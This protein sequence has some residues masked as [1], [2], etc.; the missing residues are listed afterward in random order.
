MAVTPEILLDAA[1]A[2]GK[3]TAE[4]DRRNAVSRAYYAAFHRCRSVAQ[5]ARLSVAETGSVHVALIDALVAPLTPTPLKSIGY[6]LDQ[7]RRMR[8]DADYGIDQDFP[9]YLA[10]NVLRNCRKI[11]QKADLVGGE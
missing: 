8:A 4:V 2:I 10:K 7:C 5:D 6:M 3:G 1:I 11:L 9:E